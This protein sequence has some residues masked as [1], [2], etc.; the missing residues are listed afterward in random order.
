MKECQVLVPLIRYPTPGKHF[1]AAPAMCAPHRAA[2]IG[3]GHAACPDELLRVQLPE[4]C[5]SF[6]S[7]K[8]GPEPY[9]PISGQMLHP[10]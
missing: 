1:V 4:G 3:A 10:S 2:A 7:H 9:I 5:L 8:S 6:R